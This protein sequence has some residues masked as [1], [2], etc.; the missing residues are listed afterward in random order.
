[1]GPHNQPLGA[2]QSAVETVETVKC[3]LELPISVV[4]PGLWDVDSH[5]VTWHEYRG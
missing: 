2:T 4:Q 5:Y 3:Q 1:M